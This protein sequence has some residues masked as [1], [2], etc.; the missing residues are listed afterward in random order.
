MPPDASPATTCWRNAA[1]SVAQI[2]AADAL[3]GPQ[4]LARPFDGHLPDLQHVR[5]AGGVER[6]S[7]VLLHDEDGQ[8]FALIQLGHDAEDL[9]H[10]ER[11]EPERRL[12]QHQ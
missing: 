3:V 2:A 1:T 9:A 4:L 8:A 11:R 12:V 6:E 10:D 7:C 5:A